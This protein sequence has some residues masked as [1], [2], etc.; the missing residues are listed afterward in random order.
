MIWG[1]GIYFGVRRK[2]S[3]MNIRIKKNR[4]EYGNKCVIP[5]PVVN[6]KTHYYCINMGR[7]V[8]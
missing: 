8:Q 3:L 1:P 5:R 7:Q 2:E 6:V 4:Q